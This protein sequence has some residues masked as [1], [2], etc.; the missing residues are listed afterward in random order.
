MSEQ[1]QISALINQA[2]AARRR[3]DWGTAISLL[4][5]A[6]T[7][8]PEHGGAH[9][10]LALALLGARRL[11]AASI[12]VDLAL[13]FDGNSPYA[14]YAAAAVRCA[15]RKLTDAWEHVQVALQDD[16][17]AD[18]HVLAASIRNLQGQP[19]AARTLL[20]EAL[21]LQADHVEALVESARLEHSLGNAAEANAYIDRALTLSPGDVDAH[22][23]AGHIALAAGNVDAA[24]NHARFALNEDAASRDALRLWTGV[25][26][27]RNILLG[28]W[29]RFSSVVSLRS[30]RSQV[31]LLIGSFLVVRLAIIILGALGFED[32]EVFLSK[33][34]LGFC[35]YTWIA[36][37]VFGWMLKR[38]LGTVTLREDY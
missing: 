4:Q 13:A 28:L 10:S 25:K 23:V 6:L 37:E 35:A 34:W 11:A 20:A 8:D 29:W 16:G 1:R 22:I 38:E 26:A 21:A 5:K 17:D 19:E 31:T 27:R 2:D 15:E 32:L 7:I 12:E 24:E 14:H 9:T 30:E 18:T 36:P 3:H 33:V